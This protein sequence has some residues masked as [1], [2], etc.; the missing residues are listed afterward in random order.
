MPRNLFHVLQVI[1]NSEEE[2]NTNKMIARYLVEHM[3]EI[4]KLSIYDLADGCFI[5]NSTVSRFAKSLGVSN[6]VEMKEMLS[7]Y[8]D[9][10][11]EISTD[12][13]DKLDLSPKDP[14]A[15]FANYIDRIC[16]SLHV[17][18]D[19]SFEEINALNQT[20][21]DTKNV[22]VFGTELTGLLIRY[23]QLMM[24]SIGKVVYCCD[25]NINAHSL[26]KG[27][28]PDDLAVVVSN[29]GNYLNG[30]KDII[31][32]LRKQGCKMVLITQNPTCRYINR[33]D[34]VVYM[35]EYSESIASHHKQLLMIEAII[36]LYVRKFYSQK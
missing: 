13:M 28:G 22:Y 18:E 15:N 30:N 36:N 35:G 32:T 10:G 7:E 21:H 3:H 12:I 29:D 1:V 4:D 14:K 5:S 31:L 27:L 24:M 9:S 8:K 17:M 33:F 26:V 34:Q 23:Y 20:I 16:K 19:V 11:F 25:D 6:F 2:S